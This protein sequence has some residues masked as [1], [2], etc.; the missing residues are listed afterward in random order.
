[1]TDQDFDSASLA[2]LFA[3]FNR[4][5]APGMVVGV[6]RHGATLFRRAFGLASV[7]HGVANSVRT[8]MRIGSTSKHFACLAALLL[9]E[10]GRLDLD[11]GVRRYLPE[12]PQRRDDG[13]EPTL[14]QLMT[15]TGGMRDSL[16]VGF[17]ASGMTI[18]PKGESMA[19]QLRQQDIN[20]A[21]GD[22]TVYNNGGYHM[23]SHVIARV[24]GMPFERFL[25][26]RIFTPLG[27][28]DSA[29]VPS[30]FMILP[31]VATLHVPQPD[32]GWRRGMFPSEEVLGEG[33]IVSTVDDMLRWLAHLRAPGIVGGAHSWEQMLAP[34]RLNNGLLTTY[35]LGL[36]VEQYRGVDV[37]HHGG[38]VIGGHC[39]M[40]TVPGHGL[41]VII[42]SNGAQVSLFDLANQ[43]IEAVL[44]E[45]T[46]ATAP[47]TPAATADFAPL[48]GAV[49]ASPSGD[50]VVGFAD[51]DGKLGLLVH[52]SP[53]LA[54]RV[55]PGALQLD[56]NR[57]ATGP[58]RIAIEPS[59]QGDAAPATLMFEDAGT[60]HQLERLPPPPALAQ[61]GEALLGRYLSPDLNATAAIVADG[62]RLLLRIA[63]EFGS[64][65]LDLTP[66]SAELFGWKFVGDLAPLGGT[67]RVERD[68]GTVTGVRLNTL[69]TRH[70]YLQRI[71]S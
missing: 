43:V 14:R 5:D 27:M 59:R 2:A 55:E 42:I 3:P 56:F 29:S 41:D 24:A 26:E 51:A 16:D 12:L 19:V 38:T 40:L 15:H 47:H 52:N 37:I 6:A 57:S 62:E 64:N 4:G 48:A 50:L 70:M 25:A 32:G 44:G 36:M 39:Q 65:V 33:G 35:A 68:G 71:G 9:A 53:P 49:Y 66:Y 7:E 54:L 20:F 17:L 69:R 31:G 23:L 13:Q 34:A 46:F 21:P 30:D 60:P 67:L 63:G 28:V 11:V 1:M 22:K 8:R 45:E 18:K 61:A 10:E 58:Y